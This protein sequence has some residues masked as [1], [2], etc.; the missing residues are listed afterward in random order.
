MKDNKMLNYIKEVIEN[1]PTGWL[2]ITTHRLDIYE[3]KLAKTQFLD[4]FEMLFN[5]NNSEQEALSKLPTA[6]DY[7]RLGHP[8]SCMLEWTIANL[9][10]LKPEN[11]ISFSSQ[12]VP[13]LAVL[14]KNLF[15]KKNTQLLYTGELPAYF[16]V[17]VVK[18]VYGYNFELKQIENADTVSKFDGSTVSISEE[19]AF[20]AQTLNPNIDFYIQRYENLGSLL[21][22]NG[23]ANESYISD[24]QH[25]RRRETIAM[26]PAD[27]LTALQ[28]VLGETSEAKHTDTE[29]NNAIVLENI[30]TTNPR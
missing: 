30:K 7:I 24:I 11:V 12:T 16:D 27:S 20:S 28:L 19:H 23:D 13:V 26:T 17:E 10:Q 6:Y 1:M 14:R 29:T 18:R 21:I 15:L 22:V 9:H 2:N 25:V 5:A 4:E 8:L 3:E